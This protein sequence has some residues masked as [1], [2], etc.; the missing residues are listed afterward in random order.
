[1]LVPQQDRARPAATT[2]SFK[3]SVGSV[4]SE[5]ANRRRIRYVRRVSLVRERLHTRG[6]RVMLDGPRDP[7]KVN[8][9]PEMHAWVY[10][11][12]HA[13]VWAVCMHVS[14]SE[15]LTEPCRGG[16]RCRGE[17]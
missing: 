11:C 4:S 10:V 3:G 13:M 7:V 6:V 2:I 5:M 1:V 8:N 9:E 16:A 14:G 15:V 17:G 12:A